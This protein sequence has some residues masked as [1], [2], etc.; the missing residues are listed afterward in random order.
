MRRRVHPLFVACLGLGL[1][2]GCRVPGS[3]PLEY[4]PP[5]SQDVG[6]GGDDSGRCPSSPDLDADGWQDPS[7]GGHDCNANDALYTNC[8]G[9]TGGATFCAP[10]GEEACNGLDDDCDGFVDDAYAVVAPG[11]AVVAATGRLLDGDQPALILG[12]PGEGGAV[13]AVEIYDRYGQ[14]VVRIEGIGQSAGFG[15]QIA[16]GADLDGDRHDDLVIADPTATNADGVGKGR[17]FVLEYP[18]RAG[19]TLASAAGWFEGGELDGQPGGQLAIAPDLDG[20]GLNELIIGYYR[21]V[22]DF[23]GVPRAG[24]R[25]GDAAWTLELAT[26]GGPWHFASKPDTDGDA[27]PELLLG[28]ETYDSGTGWVG[29]IDSSNPGTLAS[30]VSDPAFPGL[31]SKLV[32]VGGVT[33]S[34][35]NGVPVRLDT[36]ETLPIPAVSLADG[37]D[38]DGDG[39]EDLLVE[40]ESGIQAPSVSA[41]VVAGS[42][43]SDRNLAAPVDMDGDDVPDPP[44]LLA[45]AEVAASGAHLFLDPCDEDGDG[46]SGPAGDCDDADPSLSPT[47]HEACDGVDNDCDGAA[48][49]PAE[50][51]LDLDSDPLDLVIVAAGSGAAD[52]G[53]V[54]I[55]DA[56]GVLGG[57]GA[58][59]S[60][61][62]SGLSSIAY[63][64]D[65]AGTGAVTIL[66]HGDD[67]DVVLAAGANG[68]AATAALAG[69]VDGVSFA[70][71]GTLGTPGDFDGDGIPEVLIGATDTGGHLA[72]ALYSGP[73]TT[74]STLDDANWL[75]NLPTAWTSAATATL[76]SGADGDL[77]GDGLADLLV[78]SPLSYYGWGRASVFGGLGPGTWDA[79]GNALVD[80]YGEPEEALGASVAVGGDVDG[81][82]AADALVGGAR[83]ARIVHGAACPVMTGVVVA[84]AEW[85]GLVDLDGDG[86]SEAIA[87]GD[88]A[89]W[90]ADSVW[91]HAESVWF[92][93]GQ[94]LA[95][96][97]ALGT[98]V[99][100]PTCE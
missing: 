84:P 81:D 88:Q 87:G 72:I 27:R 42:L 93:G 90:R 2:S 32:T 92:A 46:S 75:L 6:V 30:T 83:G 86:V 23:S 40:T 18:I 52:P 24:A 54:A 61:S 12:F 10:T 13:G 51:R 55:L 28:M 59:S 67:E 11:G 47:T 62:V 71:N 74:V 36:F 70:R 82:G 99:G 91:R 80:W 53:D 1:A 78:G 64:G 49:A 94:G 8:A 85:V 26:G 20:D 79:N 14:F 96:V 7:T 3:N 9:D 44:L 95:W 15:S 56:S 45:T 39:N 5:E 38:L 37:G 41:R 29:E 50:L 73:E 19:T 77:N 89:L 63:A 31:G 57:F 58:W 35:S 34:I 76:P 65:A 66:G 33:W 100:R 4:P 98:W 60:A 16:S 48:D 21:H 69:F 43:Q 97:D 68:D 25:L 22:L 17:V